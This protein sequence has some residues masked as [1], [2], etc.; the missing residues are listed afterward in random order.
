MLNCV[1]PLLLLYTCQKISPPPKKKETPRRKRNL[2]VAFSHSNP[3]KSQK[4]IL[5]MSLF[6]L[7][8]TA[9]TTNQGTSISVFSVVSF[10]TTYRSNS[11]TVENGDL[12]RSKF[13]NKMR[14]STILGITLAMLNRFGK[15][16]VSLKAGYSGYKI[17]FN[18]FAPKTGHFW[19][20]FKK[21]FGTEISKKKKK[22]NAINI[23]VIKLCLPL[24]SLQNNA[25]F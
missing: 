11:R 3:F 12:C 21:M 17:Y 8:A 2:S 23:V 5:S 10:R 24:T 14:L 22:K 1:T 9:A 15:I 20:I 7:D 4:P 25:Y 13:E 6:T 16:K 18:K 19:D